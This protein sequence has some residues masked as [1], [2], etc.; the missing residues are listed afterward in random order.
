MSGAEPKAQAT[1][2]PTV[3]DALCVVCRR[4]RA[5]EACRSKALVRIDPD[6]PPFVDPG[7]CYGCRACIP[8]CPMGAIKVASKP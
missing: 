7:R 1:A 6:E 8:A 3:D 5:R 4:C 2:I